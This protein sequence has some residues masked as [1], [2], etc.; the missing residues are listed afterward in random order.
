MDVSTTLKRF[1]LEQAFNY[2]YKAPE[3]LRRM[4][5][6]FLPPPNAGQRRREV[7]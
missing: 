6:D 2:L 5:M 1:G 3:K 4:V 7:L